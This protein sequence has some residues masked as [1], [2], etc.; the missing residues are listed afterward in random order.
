MGVILETVVS[1]LHL[2]PSFACTVEA[3]HVRA[4][5]TSLCQ[6]M[7]TVNLLSMSPVII[8]SGAGARLC[9]ASTPTPPKPFLDLIGDCSLF[10]ATVKRLFP[11]ARGQALPIV[12]AR[13]GHSRAVQAELSALGER[14]HIVLEPEPRNLVPAMVVAALVALS[15]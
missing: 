2:N 9:P 3:L 1:L 12:V 5:P 6:G 14:A 13:Y 11:L 10:A 15:G 4:R 8:C 7:G